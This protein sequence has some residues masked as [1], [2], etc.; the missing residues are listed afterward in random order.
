MDRNK[1]SEKVSSPV[2]IFTNLDTLYADAKPLWLALAYLRSPRNAS[3]E[4][5]HGWMVTL[6]FYPINM[7]PR[8]RICLCR[9][10]LWDCFHR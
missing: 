7:Q 10:R 3:H 4:V 8:L 5:L 2:M 6:V 1:L 9:E